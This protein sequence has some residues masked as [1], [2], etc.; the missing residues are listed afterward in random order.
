[1]IK[2]SF[3][4]PG[5]YVIFIKQL[6]KEELRWG[7]IGEIMGTNAAYPQ[8]IVNGKANPK[9]SLVLKA[10]IG[11]KEY[12]EKH[13]AYKRHLRKTVEVYE[14]D[15]IV[16]WFNTHEDVDYLISEL[17]YMPSSFQKYIL[18]K[19][20]DKTIKFLTVSELTWVMDK[21]DDTSLGDFD[22]SNKQFYS[23]AKKGATNGS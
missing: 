20:T 10:D 19:L 17:G 22:L 12:F 8:S 7:D 2:R 23:I 5:A 9:Y 16:D 13:D 6:K 11:F 1:M 4:N 21:W 14:A 15:D 18:D 3:L